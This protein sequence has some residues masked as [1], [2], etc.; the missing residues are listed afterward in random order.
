MAGLSSRN[1]Y[2][3]AMSGIIGKTWGIFTLAGKVCLSVSVKATSDK[4]NR[5]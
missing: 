4:Q 3:V 2:I 5:S 1:Q